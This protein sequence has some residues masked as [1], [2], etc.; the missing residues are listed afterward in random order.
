MN[1]LRQVV[2]IVSTVCFSWLAMMVAHEV[3]HVLHAW[4][5][6]GTISK[7]VLHP[8]VISQTDL[9]HNP[10]PYFVAW[11]GPIWGCLIPLILLALARLARVGFAFLFRFFAGFCLIANGVYIGAGS[12]VGAGDAGDLMRLG[13]PQWLL[14]LF[15]IATCPFGMCLWHG[16][17][18]SF[19][20]GSPRQQVD[21][22]AAVVVPVALTLLVALELWLS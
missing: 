1:R 11:G 4:W 19:G 13:S 9:S 17:G 16:L 8:L 12:F 22:R 20:M 7:V 5:S 2:L 21:R 6:G 18:P 3:G 10:H 14:I 15:G